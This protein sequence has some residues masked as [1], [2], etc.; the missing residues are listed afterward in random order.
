[1]KNYSMQNNMNLVS[2]RIPIMPPLQTISTNL[3]Q[4]CMTFCGGYGSGNNSDRSTNLSFGEEYLNN[5]FTNTFS[6]PQ[7]RQHSYHNQSF[8]ASSNSNIMVI[9]R[10]FLISFTLLGTIL[11]PTS[12]SGP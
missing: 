4:S 12:E 9:S 3:N 1:M 7:S 10:N 5:A 11:Y 2:S 6:T 8:N